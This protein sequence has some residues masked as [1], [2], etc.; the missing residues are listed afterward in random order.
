MG[1]HLMGSRKQQVARGAEVREGTEV[2]VN[3]GE[4]SKARSHRLFQTLARNVDFIPRSLIS[5]VW[6]PFEIN[7]VE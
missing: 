3:T 7:S 2:P 5:F 4:V 1:K 6:S